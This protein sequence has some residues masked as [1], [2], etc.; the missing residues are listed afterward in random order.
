MMFICQFTHEVVDFR[1]VFT[2][3]KPWHEVLIYERLYVMERLLYVPQSFFF[4]YFMHLCFPYYTIC[5]GTLNQTLSRR[6]NYIRYR[7]FAY[8]TL[9]SAQALFSVA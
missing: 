8:G 9:S 1:H 7:H 5:N 4:S 2:V 6:F 3:F